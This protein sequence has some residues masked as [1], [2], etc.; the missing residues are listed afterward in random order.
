MDWHGNVRQLKNSVERLLIMTSGEP[1]QP[2]TAAMLPS[3]LAGATFG[4]G[5]GSGMESLM[6]LP[7]R[8][9]REA[10]E[11]DYIKAQ[12][13]RFGGNISKTATFVGM[14]RS[15]LH[16]KIRALDITVADRDEGEDQPAVVS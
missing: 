15:A 7:L 10:F 1:G 4:S 2:I 11:S 13:S 9:A 8:E 6:S 5:A 3:D 14:E 12:L 16:R